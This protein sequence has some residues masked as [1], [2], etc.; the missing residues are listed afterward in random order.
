MNEFITFGPVSSE[1]T[2]PQKRTS[3]INKPCVG[4][5]QSHETSKQIGS[6]LEKNTRH[7]LHDRSN[8]LVHDI[9]FDVP[10]SKSCCL[11]LLFIL[12]HGDIY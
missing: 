2:N 5:G 8:F 1:K 11:L 4:S 9:G 7:H 12:S 3:L 10:I 6:S